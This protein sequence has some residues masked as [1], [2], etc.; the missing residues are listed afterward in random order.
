MWGEQ[1]ESQDF[2]YLWHPL[3]QHRGFHPLVI[4]RGQGSTVYDIEDRAFLDAAAGLWCVNV[5][6]GRSELIEAATRQMS[7]LPYYPLVQSHPAALHLAERLADLLPGL[8]HLYFSNS[9]SEA[10]EIA[11]K[12]VRQYWKQMGQPAK[13]KILSRHRGY[14]GSTLGALSATGQ[15]ERRRDYEPLVPGFIQVSAPYCYRCPFLQTMPTTPHQCALD[16]E[17]R[18]QIEGPETVAAIIVEPVV[19]GGGVLVPPD[20]YLMAV[21]EIARRNQVK[22]IVDEVVTA[23]GRTGDMFAHQR[24]GVTPDVVTMAKGLASGYMPIGATAV[25][26]EIFQAF[27]GDVDSGRHLRHVNTFGGHP[28]AAA[29][30]LANIDVIVREDLVQRSRQQGERLLKFLSESL[31]GLDQV[32]DIRGRGLLVGIE[33]VQDRASKTSAPNHIM[34]TLA[35]YLL[36]HNI[37]AGKS[38]DVEADHNNILMLAPPLV[39][40]DNELE[41]LVDTVTAAIRSLSRENAKL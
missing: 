20:D 9:G 23:F 21:A 16:F 11:F 8:P 26:D 2:S 19:A 28:V 31:V 32:G 3:T 17:R 18:I 29:V 38:T 24:Y 34:R 41:Q 14:H 37:L 27:L 5:G 33:I 15:T 35:R 6:Y 13:V 22:L 1:A 10:N 39:I 40:S 30:S 4:E 36:D 7:M 12:I 25:S